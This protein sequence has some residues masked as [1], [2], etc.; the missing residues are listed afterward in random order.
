MAKKAKDFDFNDFVRQLQDRKVEPAQVEVKQE[1]RY[2]LI[3]SEGI[4][5]EPIYFEFL[6]QSLPRNLLK[7]IEVHGEGDNTVN[8]VRKAI[9]L[10]NERKNNLLLPNYDEVWAVYDK[11][12]FP[13]AHYHE[14]IDLAQRNGIES[15]HSN[16]S[17]ELWY[18][19]HF[20]FLQT[21]LHRDDY[22][23][24]LNRELGFRYTKNSEAVVRHIQETG[25]VLRA[26]RWAEELEAVHEGQ[27]PA[28]SC[29]ETRVYELVRRLRTYMNL[30]NSQL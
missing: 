13:N 20:Q 29:P 5:T 28:D 15:G 22:I 19:L 11:D 1:R 6:S 24:I 16:Q 27:R 3:V 23:H 4:R 26:I 21:A 25:N 18:V 8:V 10:R 14:A 9:E 2:F 17:F 12:D 30:D 7:T